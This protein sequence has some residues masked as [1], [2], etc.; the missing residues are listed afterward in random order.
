VKRLLA[1]L[2]LVGA[3]T[4]VFGAQL[5]YAFGPGVAKPTP[6]EMK[7][8]DH[9]MA[10][11]DCAEMAAPAKPQPVRDEST[12]CK[13]MTFA[14]IAQMGCTL[15]VVLRSGLEPAALAPT[16]AISFTLPQAAPLPGRSYAPEPEPPTLLI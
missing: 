16:V 2:L 9:D 8:A 5:A 7:M 4:G 1:L 10:G 13:G 11:M 14:C 15:P 6:T 3:I 12:P